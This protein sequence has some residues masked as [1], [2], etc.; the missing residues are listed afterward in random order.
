MAT[1]A[2]GVC[3]GDAVT[4]HLCDSAGCALGVCLRG[5]ERDALRVLGRIADRLRMGA[6]LYGPLDIAHDKRDWAKEAGDELL[7][8][9]VYL[10]V[11]RLKG[12]G[13]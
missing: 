5:L 9:C 10:A 8:G 7:D 4:D 13:R 3:G 12:E 1:A 2:S 6:R 11:E